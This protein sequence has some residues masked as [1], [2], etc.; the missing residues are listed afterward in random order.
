MTTAATREGHYEVLRLLLKA[1]ASQPA[2]EEA[3]LE[4]CLAG[5]VKMAELLIS[6]EMARPEI[7]TSALIHAS[8]R[9]LIDIVEPL[10]KV[11]LSEMLSIF[12][13]CI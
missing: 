10:I 3:L 13:A 6:C 11:G 7:L 12:Y 1:G 5:Q 4:A 8:S 2:C 9:G